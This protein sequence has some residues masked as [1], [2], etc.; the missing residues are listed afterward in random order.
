M[1]EKTDV[2]GSDSSTDGSTDL[3]SGGV[4]YKNR[5]RELE[6]KLHDMEERLSARETPAPE[7]VPEI[8]Q[9]LQEFVS[10]PNAYIQKTLAK[11][12]FQEETFEASRWLSGQSGYSPD[13]DVALVRIMRE[14]GL[15]TSSNFPLKRAQ[16]AWKL[17][18][19]E[20]MEKNQTTS[21]ND[22]E[23]A[24]RLSSTS[25]EGSGRVV[26]IKT[27]PSKVEAIKK[28]KEAT[29]KGDLDGEVYWNEVI[30]N[31]QWEEQSKKK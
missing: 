12:R 21:Q 2:T 7:P 11:N 30:E 1:S 8:N 23:R 20:K 9:D 14:H 19:A 13:D 26:P 5:V 18:R 17:L 28:F 16:T 6:R 4:P 25:P 31:I 3:D 29:E 22:S 27:G 15:Q 24:E 10:N